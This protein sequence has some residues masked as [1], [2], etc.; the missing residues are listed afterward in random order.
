MIPR[1]KLIFDVL[2]SIAHFKAWTLDH[3]LPSYGVYCF[4][5]FV[6]AS[7]SFMLGLIVA[8][9]QNRATEKVKA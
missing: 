2:A 5:N 8:E 9:I 3:W 6:S 1:V 7:L 4:V